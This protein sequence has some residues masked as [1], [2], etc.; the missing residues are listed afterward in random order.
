M[1]RALLILAAANGFSQT[2]PSFDVA[3]IKP[4]NAPPGSSGG[5]SGE[6]RLTWKNVTLR[7]MIRGAYDVSEPQVIG[8]PKWVDD[9]RFDVSAKSDHA[10]GD[11]E[12]MLMVQ[13][14]LADRF[15][16][17]THRETRDFRGYALVVAKGGLKAMPSAPG[18]PFTTSSGRTTVDV[19]GCT[20]AEFGKRLSNSLGFPVTDMTETPGA[21]DIHLKWTPEDPKPNADPGI[22]V[23]SA[24]QD[25]GL[26]LDARKIPTEVIVIDSVEHP[27]EN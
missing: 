22:S 15:R 3:S 6:G 12:M 13:A 17:V 9:E 26:R 19:T 5:H 25:L 11:S 18:T 4:S 23:F 21:F 1:W 14:L 2:L 24:L 10:A 16:L 8:G 27:T 7:R 20:L